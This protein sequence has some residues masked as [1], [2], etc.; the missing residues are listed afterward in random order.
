MWLDPCVQ[1]MEQL[2]SL[3]L[4]CKLSG[5]ETGLF[6]TGIPRG[7]IGHCSGLGPWG[8]AVTRHQLVPRCWSTRSSFHLYL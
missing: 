1:L 7:T 8:V 6:Y 3:G 2:A 5:A 4:E